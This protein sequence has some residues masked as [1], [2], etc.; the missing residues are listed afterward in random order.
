MCPSQNN[1]LDPSLI[2]TL[3]QDQDVLI[4]EVSLSSLA[5]VDSHPPTKVVLEAISIIIIIIL[6]VVIAVVAIIAK[7]SM[8]ISKL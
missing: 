1:F 5:R 4:Q 8:I 6:V 2:I 3:N 7:K